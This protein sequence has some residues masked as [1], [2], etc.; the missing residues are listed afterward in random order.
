MGIV[1]PGT[2]NNGVVLILVT[3][4]HSAARYH[5]THEPQKVWSKQKKHSWRPLNLGQGEPNESL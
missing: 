1:Q 2:L 4:K 3:K 5:H